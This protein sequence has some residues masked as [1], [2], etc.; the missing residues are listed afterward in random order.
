MD[1]RSLT[2][3]FLETFDG[4]ARADLARFMSRYPFTPTWL[5]S[6]DYVV[7]DKG[8][9]NDVFAFSIMPYAEPL[10]AMQARVA[11][12]LPR[13]IKAT[14][15]FT[16]AAGAVLRGLE[17]FHVPVVLPKGRLLLGPTGAESVSAGRKAAVEFVRDAIV[18]E[19][20]IDAV[21]IMRKLERSTA[22]KGYSH[23]LLADVLL[24]AL[25][26]AILS[27]L[28]LRERRGAKLVWMSDR[29]TMT[30]W[31]GGVV[32]H[33]AQMDLRG[34]CDAVGLDRGFEAPGVCVPGVDGKMWFDHLVRLPDHVAGALSAWDT[35]TDGP[36]DGSRTELVS[37]MFRHVFAGADNMAM[38]RFYVGP[39][40]F[41]W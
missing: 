12:G 13:D 10:P 14:K 16:S 37:D 27:A 1:V 21:R 24:L 34:V 36:V 7:G 28:V 31:C 39:E 30:S 20:G 32:W 26:F 38:I 11:A 29:D 5:I 3:L 15:T 9:P 33:I 8:R 4:S 23:R 6:A 17:V 25:L 40:R 22:G 18:M 41:G 35:S 19:R 2:A